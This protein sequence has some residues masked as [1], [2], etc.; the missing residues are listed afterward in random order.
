MED[1]GMG[2]W[3]GPTIILHENRTGG[4][5]NKE[6]FGPVLSMHYVA[7]WQEVVEIE[8]ANPY[9]NAA[10]IYTTNRGRAECFMSRVWA[11]VSFISL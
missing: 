11:S 3:I 5:M 4:A 9:G 8:N 6:V 7:T 1:D 10:A 2:N